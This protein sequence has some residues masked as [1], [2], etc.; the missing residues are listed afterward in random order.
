MM[1]STSLALAFVTLL[2]QTGST[3]PAQAMPEGLASVR[4]LYASGAYEDALTRL[5]TLAVED[6]GAGQYRALC[7][8]ALGR[9]ADA[10]RSL[11]ELVARQ[12]LFRMSDADVSPQLTN[13]FRDVRRRVL[14]TVVRDL[15]A[16]ARTSFA[17]RRHREASR[18]FKD[19]LALLTDEDLGDESV[20][21]SDFKLLAEEFLKLAELEMAAAPDAAASA[22]TVEPPPATAGSATSRRV[23]RAGDPSVLPPVDVS[24]PMPPWYPPTPAD[25]AREHHGIL[26][27]VIDERGYVEEASLVKPVSDSYDAVL[28]AATKHWKFRPAVRNG[29]AVKFEKLIDV[30]LPI[31]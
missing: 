28:L 25:Q 8:L 29:A 26:R 18:Q 1:L 11:E 3:G 4:L 2:G 30:V 9:N 23:Y 19:V 22:S 31:R 7:L 13:L 24:R 27:I 10:R 17:E 12:P 15:Y 6:A 5:S 16:A 20:V 21:L 14:P